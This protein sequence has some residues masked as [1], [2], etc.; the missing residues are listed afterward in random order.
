MSK[1]G[2]VIDVDCVYN[3]DDPPK[4][5][6]GSNKTLY[7]FAYFTCQDRVCHTDSDDDTYVAFCAIV[8]GQAICTANLW[9]F[10]VVYRSTR[11][12]A[13]VKV[14]L[15]WNTALRAVRGLLDVYFA[16]CILKWTAPAL[17][18]DE[19]P[20]KP[21]CLS[22]ANYPWSGAMLNQILSTFYLGTAVTCQC[23]EH[24]ITI[25]REDNPEKDAVRTV[26]STT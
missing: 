2:I 14:N 13:N 18:W 19:P 7:Q 16:S 25:S 8:L 21:H 11:M 10:C 15:L 1:F 4:M 22:M 24:L 3:M 26:A 17:F 23:L 20:L 9:A 6:P 5:P 12:G